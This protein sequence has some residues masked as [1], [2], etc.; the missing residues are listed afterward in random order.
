MIP[1]L[2]QLHEHQFPFYF[3]KSFA[4]FRIIFFLREEVVPSTFHLKLSSYQFKRKKLHI[5]SGSYGTFFVL[6]ERANRQALGFQRNSI[7]ANR[8][9]EHLLWFYPEAWPITISGLQYLYMQSAKV[10]LPPPGGADE[11]ENFRAWGTHFAL[12]MGNI[13]PEG[14]LVWAFSHAPLHLKASFLVPISVGIPT[15]LIDKA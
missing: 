5:I 2:F 9:W 12:L 13:S 6:I 1:L 10:P 14:P 7:L 15:S 4:R 11:H 3:I 8:A